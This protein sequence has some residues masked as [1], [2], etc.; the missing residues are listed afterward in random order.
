MDLWCDLNRKAS[1]CLSW[2]EFI[3]SS[4]AQTQLL[5]FRIDSCMGQT[6]AKAVAA[7]GNCK[8]RRQ[9]SGGGASRRPEAEAD[10]GCRG[11]CTLSITGLASGKGKKH[12]YEASLDAQQRL[13]CVC[14][15]GCGRGCPFA[16]CEPRRVIAQFHL[17]RCCLV[18]S[19]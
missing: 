15:K 18:N 4:I 17:R 3:L 14:P 5:L 19:K 13:A 10:R 9:D 2:P 6:H 7:H 1:R 8:H 12:L 11:L 16:G